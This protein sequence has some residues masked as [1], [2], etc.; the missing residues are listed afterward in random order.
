MDVLDEAHLPN[1]CAVRSAL[2]TS[3]GSAAAE[4][5]KASEAGGIGRDSVALAKAGRGRPSVVLAREPVVVFLTCALR[6]LRVEGVE[7]VAHG[8]GVT[9]ATR[10]RRVEA[11][12]RYARN[13]EDE[14]RGA[15]GNRRLVHRVGVAGWMEARRRRLLHNVKVQFGWPVVAGVCQ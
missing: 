14:A 3:K 11:S 6:H 2:K 7:H 1:V 5:I 10:T 8:H 9:L 13:L 12:T 15:R 4:E